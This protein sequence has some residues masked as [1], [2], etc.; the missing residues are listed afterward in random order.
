MQVLI[1]VLKAYAKST[2]GPVILGVVVVL[3]VQDYRNQQMEAR[4]DLRFQQMEQ[5][6]DQQDE[7]LDRIASRLD[8]IEVQVQRNST[9][10]AVLQ[11]RIMHLHPQI[12]QAEV[13]PAKPPAPRPSS[14]G[15]GR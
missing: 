15:T 11:E 2:W 12:A 5:R 8:R 6:F 7:R 4:M 10:I 3:V 1:E 13:E 14:G 9:Q